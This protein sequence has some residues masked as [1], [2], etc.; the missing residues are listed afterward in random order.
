MPHEQTKSFVVL[1]LTNKRDIQDCTNHRG[2]KL[3]SHIESYYEIMG[4]GDG[5]KNQK[6]DNYYKK[7][8]WF[9]AWKVDN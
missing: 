1:V 7:S 5:N 3:M 4:E 9:Y 2:I 8:I 6:I